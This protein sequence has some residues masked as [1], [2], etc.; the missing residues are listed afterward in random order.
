MI[1]ANPVLGVGMGNHVFNQHR[2]F[3]PRPPRK[4]E[5]SANTYLQLAAEAGVPALFLYIGFFWLVLLFLLKVI[6]RCD[7]PEIRHLATCLLAALAAFFV[8]AATAHAL[9]NELAWSLLGLS[10]GLG[11]GARDPGASG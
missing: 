9:Y 2:F 4:P 6:I 5:N 8:F 11:N 1:E 10:V 3:D 7:D